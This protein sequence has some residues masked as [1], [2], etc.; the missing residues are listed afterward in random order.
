M[1]PTL[2]RAKSPYSVVPFPVPFPTSQ[3]LN[4]QISAFRYL[5]S[6]FP[7][8]TLYYSKIY[9]LFIWKKASQ[10]DRITSNKKKIKNF[11]FLN[12]LIIFHWILLENIIINKIKIYIPMR[13]LTGWR[14]VGHASV[15]IS[16]GAKNNFSPCIFFN[17]WYQQIFYWSLIWN[18]S[19]FF[20]LNFTA[21]SCDEFSWFS[22]QKYI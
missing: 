20:F 12:W 9:Y 5:H 2:S 1:I 17:Q 10:S 11:K 22:I 15:A 14:K 4:S 16:W 13:Y 7:K 19:F 6:K 3:Q 8:T 18:F 21:N